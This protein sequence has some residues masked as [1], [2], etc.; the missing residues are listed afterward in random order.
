[1]SGELPVA[2]LH[3]YALNRLIC[4]P[5]A[6]IT[7]HLSEYATIAKSIAVTSLGRCL[8]KYTTSELFFLVYQSYN[9]HTDF[10]RSTVVHSK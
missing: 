5:G 10:T 4:E 7:T 2:I 9:Y 3:H 8:A 1:M 6:S